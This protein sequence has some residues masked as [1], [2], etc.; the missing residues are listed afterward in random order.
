[1]FNSAHRRRLNGTETRALMTGDHVLV[2]NGSGW[3]AETHFSGRAGGYLVV[4][5]EGGDACF[6]LQPRGIKVKV[7]SS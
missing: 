7:K 5:C 3:L 6:V 4:V 1:M 2:G